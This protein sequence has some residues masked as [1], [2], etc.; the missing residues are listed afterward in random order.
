M[1]EKMKWEVDVPI[2]RN[3]L[4]LKQLGL[5]I[6]VP[7][8][9]LI[10]ILFLITTEIRYVFYSLFLIGFLFILTYIIIMVLYGGRYAVGFVIDTKGIRCYTQ[11]KQAK[12][13]KII[14]S[15]AILL[16]IFSSKPGIAGA[17]MLAQTRQ[18][19]RIKW[20]HIKKVNYRPR[21]HM[22]L[23]KG[24]FAE[25]IAVFCTQENYEQAKSVIESKTS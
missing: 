18:D 22:I 3:P 25:H 6:G 13:N 16:G 4:I 9:I 21:K 8:G 7:F 20:K 17:G 24:N 10:L 23:V 1:I 11:K 14:N 2:F 5:A 15:L 12:K 19:I